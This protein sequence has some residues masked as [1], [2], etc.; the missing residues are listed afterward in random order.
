[1]PL[2]FSSG[3]DESAAGRPFEPLVVAASPVN[4]RTIAARS[5]NTCETRFL[6]RAPLLLLASTMFTSSDPYVYMYLY[7]VHVGLRLLQSKQT[8]YGVETKRRCITEQ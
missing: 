5:V 7:A 3:S 4:D 6:L 1:M 2:S 8:F